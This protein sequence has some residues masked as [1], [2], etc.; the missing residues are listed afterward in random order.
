MGMA[1]HRKHTVLSCYEKAAKSHQQQDEDGGGI[2][3]MDTQVGT[4]VVINDETANLMPLEESDVD[5]V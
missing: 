4:V 3:D 1:H 2:L 5:I